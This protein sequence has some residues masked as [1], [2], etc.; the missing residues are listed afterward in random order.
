MYGFSTERHHLG[1]IEAEDE[2]DAINVAAR[3]TDDE[4]LNDGEQN[5]ISL[6]EEQPELFL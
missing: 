1:S 4:I 3:L 2:T 6:S 5:L